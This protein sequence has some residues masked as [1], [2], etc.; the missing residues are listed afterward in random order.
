MSKFLKWLL[1]LNIVFPSFFIANRVNAED[2]K[3]TAPS[4]IIAMTFSNPKSLIQNL[5]SMTDYVLSQCKSENKVH[6][7]FIPTASN[8]SLLER[9]F[10]QSFLKGR[11]L[12]NHEKWKAHIFT[13]YDLKQDRQKL[14][15][16]LGKQDVIFIGSGYTK[17]MMEYW[18]K[19]GFDQVLRELWT[20]GGIIFSGGSAG[21]ECWFEKGLTRPG[22]NNVE[23]IE[24]L[25]FLKGSC[26][27]HFQ[28]GIREY[29]FANE[30]SKENAAFPGYGCEDGVA[31][32][33]VGQ[34][35]VNVI[36]LGKNGKVV[37]YESP[38]VKYTLP[39]I[40]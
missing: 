30:M 17:N 26:S 20:R 22:A 23:M 16:K 27:P 14:I 25:G 11:G 36:P 38:T 10:F 4:Q 35:L 2:E 6:I 9:A 21:L 29:Y 19:T 31:V 5:N 7:A 1:I 32:H 18:R 39:K 8:D 15:Q 3:Q 40:N 33:F 37:F 34:E 28:E 13:K 24:T 12:L